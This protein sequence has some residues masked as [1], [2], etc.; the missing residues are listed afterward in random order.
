MGVWQYAIAGNSWVMSKY[1]VTLDGSKINLRLAPKP[2]VAL[3]ARKA[4]DPLAELLPPAKFED[5]RLVISELVANSILHAGLLPNDRISL[6]VA[7]S[8]ESVRGKVCD[9]G[10]GFE[11]PSVPRPR[12]DLSGGWGLPIVERLSDSWGVERNSCVCV[13]F[14]ID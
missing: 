14:E 6:S 2:E 12:A 11:V 7:V 4:L 5:V 1:T 10:S 3:T 13:W 8:G 9:P